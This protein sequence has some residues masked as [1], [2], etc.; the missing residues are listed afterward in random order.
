MTTRASFIAAELLFLTLT[1]L[2]GGPSWTL[3]G[4]I[5][6][7]A[8]AIADLRLAAILRLAPALVWLGLFRFTGNRELFFP[9]AMF[10]A[11]HL[12]L[13]LATAWNRTIGLAGGGLIVAAFMTIR[14][15]ERATGNV[16]AVELAVA[17]GILMLVFAT[18][19]MT[20]T[21]PT[22]DTLISVAASL[23]AYASLAL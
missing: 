7:V 16:L 5:A 21:S 4:M 22:G 12:A 3:L 18:R 8:I 10:L 9:Y 2:A 15:V 20:R 13:M 19:S 1:T 14:G 6:V 11:S 17:V 23:L